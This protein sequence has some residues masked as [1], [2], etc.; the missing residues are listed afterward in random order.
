[1]WPII[2]RLYLLPSEISLHPHLVVTKN[3]KAEIQLLFGDKM[4]E[5]EDKIKKKLLNL[6]DLY[7]QHEEVKSPKLKKEMIKL[8]REIYKDILKEII[9]EEDETIYDFIRMTC[10]FL[11]SEGRRRKNPLYYVA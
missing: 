4:K 10:E 2:T 7:C 6:V 5:K 9:N 11:I 8:G 1:L 3:Y